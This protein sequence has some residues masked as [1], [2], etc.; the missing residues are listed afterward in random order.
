[1]FKVPQT[2]APPTPPAAFPPVFSRLVPSVETPEVPRTYMSLLTSLPSFLSIHSPLAALWLPL[3]CLAYLPTTGPLHMLFLT[4]ML[5]HSPL[6]LLYTQS[7]FISQVRGHFLRE[8]LSDCSRLNQSPLFVQSK[9]HVP[10]SLS[11]H[12]CYNLLG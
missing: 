5:F 1:M 2:L 4:R 3:F 8:A 10:P 11:T 7:F 12:L 9:Y 6:Y